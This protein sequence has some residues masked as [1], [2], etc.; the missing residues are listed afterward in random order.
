MLSEGMASPVSWSS[1]NPASVLAMEKK[2]K[3]VCNSATESSLTLAQYKSSVDNIKLRCIEAYYF[4]FHSSH[5]FILSKAHLLTYTKRK[6]LPLLSAAIRY[7]GSRYL[8]DVPT[9]PILAEAED[10]LLSTSN[11]IKSRDGFRVQAILLLAIGLDGEREITRSSQHLD[12]AAN[13]AIELGMQ[14]EVFPS[15]NNEGCTFLEESWRRTFWEIYV[16]DRMM[17]GMHQ[18]PYLRLHNISPTVRLPCEEKQYETGV[19]FPNV[20]RTELCLIIS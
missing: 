9:A 20:S 5:P 14:H 6:P 17:S 11:D 1:P 15:Q 10:I 13:L 7:I 18:T 2:D 8:S 19:C 4:N 12:S 3:D 16:V